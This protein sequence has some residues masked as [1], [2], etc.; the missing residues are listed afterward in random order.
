MARTRREEG[1]LVNGVRGMREK[2]GG[3]VRKHRVVEIGLNKR[4]Q[5][6]PR[7]WRVRLTLKLYEGSLNGLMS[8]SLRQ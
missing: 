6:C 5:F 7:T 1:K 8:G 3:E 2:Q 4:L